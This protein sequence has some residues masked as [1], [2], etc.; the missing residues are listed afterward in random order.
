[1]L[2]KHFW[3]RVGIQWKDKREETNNNKGYEELNNAIFSLKWD[4][5]IK[6]FVQLI[7]IPH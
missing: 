3:S 6:D 7:P 2:V 1:M 4:Q 5:A